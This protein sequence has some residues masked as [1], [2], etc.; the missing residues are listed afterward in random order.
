MEKYEKLEK[1]GEGTYGKV[2]KAKE[3]ASGQLV[4]LKKTRL[5]MDEE[6]IPPTALRE[7]S[8]LQMLS[9]SLYIVRL[10]CVE[11]VDKASKT[12][13]AGCQPSTKPLLYLVFEYLDTDL[14]KYIDSHRKGPNP[15]P[16]APS[17][18]QS[19]L[20]QL[21]KGVA[22]CHSHGVLHRDLKP[23]NLLLDQQKGILKIAD[24]GLG[25]AFTVPLKSYT[26]EIVTLWY[27]APEVLLGSTHY[28]TG[29]DMWSVGC[30]FAEMV[31]RQALFPGD[32][33]FQQLLNIFRLLGT[34]TE[35]QWPGVTSLRDWHVY[36]RWE[37]Q[38]LARAVPSLGPEGV[39][40]LS[41]MLQYNPAERISAKAALDHP[42]FDSLDKSQF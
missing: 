7:I 24:L 23:Q 16:L 30:I 12:V 40:L 8:L 9:Q 3:K 29:V 1:V 19:F 37:P 15:R 14:K 17:L 42:Y 22:H 5:E 39:D 11:H 36:P 27:R 34:P 18:I 6:G 4:A 10:L 26:H 35:E 38:N 32:S 28:S 31:R 25:R 21:C 20:F 2:Y 13:A 33:E 41:K